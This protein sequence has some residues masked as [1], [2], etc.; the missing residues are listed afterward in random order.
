MNGDRSIEY[1]I[2][3]TKKL[4]SNLGPN[5]Y[6]KLCKKEV[7]TNLNI[8]E[9]LFLKSRESYSVK[10]RSLHTMLKKNFS[11]NRLGRAVTTVKGVRRM[12]YMITV[13]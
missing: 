1:R 10:I 2:G 7:N 13:A 5:F 11:N 4:I 8:K 6:R 12:K 9:E 3:A